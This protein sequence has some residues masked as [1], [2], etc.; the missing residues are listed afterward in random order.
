MVL[1]VLLW[2]HLLANT[3]YILRRQYVCFIFAENFPSQNFYIVLSLVLLHTT[4][5]LKLH[6]IKMFDIATDK[7]F[8]LQI[9]AFM[10][11]FPKAHLIELDTISFSPEKLKIAC[12]H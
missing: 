11:R 5:Y 2:D 4:L 1:V 8:R 6:I 10:K 9:T 12:Q 7:L 3:C